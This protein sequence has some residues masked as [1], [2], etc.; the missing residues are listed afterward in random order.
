MIVIGLYTSLAY[1][2]LVF[3]C[4]CVYS[5]SLQQFR[6]WIIYWLKANGFTQDILWSKFSGSTPKDGHFNHIYTIIILS[7]SYRVCLIFLMVLSQCLQTQSLHISHYLW[8]FD[9]ISI[10]SPFC[11]YTVMNSIIFRIETLK[12]FFSSFEC[13]SSLF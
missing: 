11:V 2:C 8:Y 7:F 4:V 13:L 12:F 5:F 6:F 9:T 10:I 3:V 1:F